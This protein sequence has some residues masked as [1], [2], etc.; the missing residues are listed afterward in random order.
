MQTVKKRVTVHVEK[1]HGACGRKHPCGTFRADT[2]HLA[3]AAGRA[4]SHVGPERR[5]VLRTERP[6]GMIVGRLAQNTIVGGP[7]AQ[8]QQAVGILFRTPGTHT[9]CDVLARTSALLPRPL[10]LQVISENS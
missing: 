1:G 8:R 2:A 7:L 6:F 4:F 3:W 5:K 9:C 10:D